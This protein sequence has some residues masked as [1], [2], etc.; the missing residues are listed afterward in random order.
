MKKTAKII[1]VATVV[2]SSALAFTSCDFLEQAP[3]NEQTKEY[4][5]LDYVRSQRFVDMLYY[6]MPNT[7]VKDGKFSTSSTTRYG[8]M[9]SATDMAE[10]S[11][12]Y[13]VPNTTFNVGDW[14]ATEATEELSNVW[15]TCYKQIRRAWMF[16]ENCDLPGSFVNEPAGRKPMMKGE[17]H[18]M[19]AFNYFELLKRYG[20]V[21]LVKKVYTLE[22]D[23]KIPRSTFDETAAFIMDE[24]VLAESL[25]PDEWTSEDFGRATKAWCKALRSRVLLYMAS[26]LNNPTNDVERWKAAA[27]AAKECIEYC[28]NNG[29]HALST[30]WQNIFLRD[31]PQ[32]NKEVII[33]SRISTYTHTFISKLINYEQATPGDGFWGYGSNGPTQNFVDRFPV[34]TFDGGGNA[35]GTVDFDWNNADHV[36]HIYQNRDP[37]FYYTVLYNDRMWITRKLETWHDGATYGKDMDPKNHLFTKTGYYLRKFWGRECKNKNNPGSCRVF[38]YFLRFTELY[39]NYAEAMNEAYGPDSDG[40]TGGMTAIEAINKTRARLKCPASGSISA[41]ASDPFYYVKVERDENPDFPVLPSG[42][43]GLPSGMSKDQAR[44]KIQNERIIEFAFEDQYFYDILRWK[45][46]EELIGGTVYGVDIIKSGESFSYS[47]MKVED[48][49]FNPRYMYR[50]PIPQ[51]EVYNLGIAQNE[52]W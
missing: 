6:N 10:Y 37:R 8:M 21:P 11:A 36:T 49:E 46:G 23:Y 51:D 27:A 29:Y 16:L 9:E 34:I 42:L 40:G 25:L 22:D 32:D 12:T 28:E 33:F 31:Y 43:P 26:P 41:S 2:L 18:F 17:C 15:Y 1:L 5:F 30:D 50:Y 14:R 20:G 4:I 47:K 7:W 44:A 45:R 19:L 13:G 38:G 24:L 3:N 35:I 52:G 39:F 48:R